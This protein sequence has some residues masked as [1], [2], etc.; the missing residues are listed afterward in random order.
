MIKN[1]QNILHRYRF[2]TAQMVEPIELTGL[3]TVDQWKE[4]QV[5]LKRLRDQGQYIGG[6]KC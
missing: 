2:N 6:R 5:T 3:P 4:T 1:S